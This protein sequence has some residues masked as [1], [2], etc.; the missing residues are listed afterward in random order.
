MRKTELLK[1]KPIYAT[2]SMMRS[3]V[4]DIPKKVSSYWGGT[5]NKYQTM[6]YLRCKKEDG[7]LRIAIFLTDNM[8]LGAKKPTFEIFIDKE[9]R[10]FITY[11]YLKDKWSNSKIDMLDWPR[12][13]Y[14]SDGHYNGRES[15]R[16]IKNNLGTKEGGYEGILAW[17]QGVR[18]EQLDKR[19]KKETDPWDE[20]MKKI[21]SV[22][23]DWKKW[24]D[25]Q[26]IPHQF[27]FYKYERKGAK[28]GWCS[29]CE[30]EVPIKNPKHNKLGKCSCC[31][32]EIQ[33]KSI[34]KAGIIVTPRVWIYLLQ[35]YEN[36]FV[37][38]EYG[39][40][41]KFVDNYRKP[42]ICFFE[43]RRVIFDENFNGEAYY[44]G[45]YKQQKVR[46]IYEGKI[47]NYAYG[48][49]YSDYR[50]QVYKRTLVSLSERLSR[51][52]LIEMIR[53]G[54]PI[55][56]ELYVKMLKS[57]PYIEQLAKARL[58]KLAYDCITR[59]D[60]PKIESYRSL[61]KSLQIDKY[62][63]NRLQKNNGGIA[64][65]EWLKFEKACQKNIAD[66][67]ISWMVKNKIKPN[68]IHFISD[69][70]SELQVK[71]YIERQQ[72]E[73]YR[74][75]KEII[76]TWQDYLSMA[77][78]AKMNT[79]DAIVFRVKKL[80]QRHDELV[81]YLGSKSLAIRAGEIASKY[82]NVD[83]VCTEIKSKYEYENDEFALIVPNSIEDILKEGQSLHHCIDKSDRYFERIHTK[84]SFLL[85]LRKKENV[86]QPWYTIEVEPGGTI[87]QK[88]TEYDRQ[89]ADLDL[90]KEF[91]IQ[92]Q[93]ELQKRLC[94]DDLLLAEKSKLLR[95]KEFEEMKEQN[96]KIAHGYLAGRSL[97]EVLEADLMEV[98][99]LISG[100]VG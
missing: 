28:T 24:V 93:K 91:L 10:D 13:N 92:W 94:D 41:K 60:A 74:P 36:G 45:Q 88:R 8:R 7:I 81:K 76:S 77:A 23:K 56:P 82:P 15:N 62:R 46:W 25:K 2:P 95:V 9:K 73:F 72:Q 35:R 100:K 14:A 70:M 87:R 11:D 97:A 19:H 47:R 96:I 38:R 5:Y 52:G 33:F 1:F 89:N 63:L 57:H 3:A 67:V 51:T 48:Y 71:N 83:D 58:T 21:T 98:S 69:R 16:F 84:E 66:E 53:S 79:R 12:Y 78:R 61:A 40:Y 59:H 18:K 4:N 6:Y 44:Y 54:E 26:G 68:D 50:G 99:Q 32:H 65:L 20:K 49:F 30:K 29:W 31:G 64:F 27:I 39:A 75:A 80:Q 43:S 37:I 42:D 90:A 22:P 85:F 55:D 34:G 86:T 17:Q